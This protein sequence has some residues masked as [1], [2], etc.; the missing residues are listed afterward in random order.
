M[1][2]FQTALCK[3][4]FVNIKQIDYTILYYIAGV[5]REQARSLL[6]S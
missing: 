2:I 4:N 1:Y 6:Q 5:R 3:R